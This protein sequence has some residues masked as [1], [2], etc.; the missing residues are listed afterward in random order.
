MNFD[1]RRNNEVL[2]RTLKTKQDFFLFSLVG[3][4]LNRVLF[5]VFKI[6]CATQ[7]VATVDVDSITCPR[8]GASSRKL[9]RITGWCCR[10]VKWNGFSSVRGTD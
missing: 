1:E 9:L 4:D 8:D 7:P 10:F 2:A 3:L 6:I 5:L